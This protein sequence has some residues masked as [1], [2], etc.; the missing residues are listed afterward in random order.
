MNDTWGGGSL[1]AEAGWSSACNERRRWEQVLVFCL[2][3]G[4]LQAGR[5]LA[6]CAS[7]CACAAVI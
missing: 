2:E 4:E 6:P 7:R 3:R 5:H 1:A